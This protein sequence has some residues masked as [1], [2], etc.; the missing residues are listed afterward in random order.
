MCSSH[1]YTCCSKAWLALLQLPV[2]VSSFLLLPIPCASF[3]LPLPSLPSPAPPPY[4][5]CS[6]A[7]LALLQL[8]I[9]ADILRK[10]L[11][12]LHSAVLPNMTNPLLLSDFLT[13]SLN[14][15]E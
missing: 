9:P 6:E 13:F 10:V 7:W 11:V 5:S 1:P 15:G 8:P 12:R 4:F 2:P 3:S 14:Q